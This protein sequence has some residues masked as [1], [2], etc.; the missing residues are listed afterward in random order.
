MLY[1]SATTF[2]T[3][4]EATGLVAL[5][6]LDR[7][8]AVACR[9]GGASHQTVWAELIAEIERDPDLDLLGLRDTTETSGGL[10]VDV[11]RTRQT[12]DF[13]KVI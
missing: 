9:R 2:N 10:K 13:L 6:D 1:A 3:L 7:R 5:V 4:R 12:S 8:P 11:A